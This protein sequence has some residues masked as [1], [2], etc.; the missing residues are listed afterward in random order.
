KKDGT[1][2]TDEEDSELDKD[3]EKKLDSDS[4][5]EA[6]RDNRPSMAQIRGK[7]IPD[8][9]NSGYHQEINH[10][11]YGHTHSSLIDLIKKKFA[12]KEAQISVEFEAEGL[13]ISNPGAWQHVEK[14]SF[15]EIY[16]DWT[17]H[18]NN[19]EK[20]VGDIEKIIDRK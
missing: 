9:I 1:K 8:L 19:V 20:K 17:V 4:H 11:I 16:T 3:L 5:R 2:L 6:L 12:P 13:S 7:F 15:L 14:P 18:P 10:V